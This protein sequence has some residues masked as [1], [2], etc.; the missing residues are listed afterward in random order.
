MSLWVRYGQRV[1][2]PDELASRRIERRVLERLET[3][4]AARARRLGAGTLVG[5]GLAAALLLV[6][7]W[8]LVPW[9]GQDPEPSWVAIS[10]TTRAQQV[11]LPHAG[12]LWVGQGSRVELAVSDAAGAVVRLHEGEVT[13]H[14]HAS[15]GLRW[16]VEVDGYHVEAIGTRFR[17]RRTEGV[18]DVLVD[19]GVV[20]LT[21]PGQLEGGLLIG[22]VESAAPGRDDGG[23]LAQAVAEPIAAG[24]ERAVEG[25]PES[26]VDVQPDPPIAEVGPDAP[27]SSEPV[28]DRRSSPRWVDRFRDAIAAGDDAS[29][30]AA[31]PAGFPTGGESLSASDYLEAGDALA[32]RHEQERADAAYRAACRRARAPA[33]GVAIFRRALMAARSGETAEAIRLATRYLD[34]HPDGTLAPEV[35]ARRMRWH[36]A[37]G[38]A[39]AARRDARS[40]LA[41]WPDGPHDDLARRIL[42]ERAGTP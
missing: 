42:G 30:V 19:E 33:C 11:S 27:A 7:G 34:D 4:R 3:R 13:L 35:L 26:P 8:A 31:L 28:L 29:A 18:P 22:A 37:Q 16:R 39:D 12:A 38:S 41:R 17:V 36:S 9:S 24:G 2:G 32:S 25:E 14:V 6:I 23:G 1:G 21:G 5:A 15:E 10:T 40:Y 20:R